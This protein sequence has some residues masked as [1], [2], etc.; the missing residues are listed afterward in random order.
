MQ[1]L[2]WPAIGL[3]GVTNATASWNESWHFGRLGRLL[4]R[5]DKTS[6]IFR[7]E[8]F[9]VITF[10]KSSGLAVRVSLQWDCPLLKSASAYEM[11]RK[12]EH[13]NFDRQVWLSFLIF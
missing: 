1:K 6:R 10:G 12:V 3:V 7:C 2:K 13:T 11:Y 9:F 5:A 8:V 4:E